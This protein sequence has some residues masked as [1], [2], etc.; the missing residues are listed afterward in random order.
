MAP[1]GYAGNRLLGPRSS[2]VYQTGHPKVQLIVMTV[3]P[4]GNPDLL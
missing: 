1:Q 2:Y 4:I 3:R